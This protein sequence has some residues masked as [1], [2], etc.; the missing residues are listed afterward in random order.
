[1][2]SA[3]VV[4]RVPPSPALIVWLTAVGVSSVVAPTDKGSGVFGNSDPP[5]AVTSSCFEAALQLLPS[6]DSATFFYASAHAITQ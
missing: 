3:P 5:D 6:F 2:P 4:V 1:M